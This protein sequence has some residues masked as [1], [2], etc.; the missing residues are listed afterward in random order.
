MYGPDRTLAYRGAMDTS[1]P[2]NDESVTGA[3]L[4][5]AIEHVLAGEPVP[6]PHTPSMGCSIKWRP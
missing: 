6:E 2:G 4:R 3:F 5:D 1:S